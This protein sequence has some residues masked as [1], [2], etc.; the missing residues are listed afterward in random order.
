MPVLRARD[1][2][3]S[4]ATLRVSE[5]GLLIKTSAWAGLDTPRRWTLVVVPKVPLGKSVEQDGH[6]KSRYLDSRNVAIGPMRQV[7]GRGLRTPEAKCTF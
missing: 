6:I 7:L 1:E 5:D 3:L 2:T 4:M